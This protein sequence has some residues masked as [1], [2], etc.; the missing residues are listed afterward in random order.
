MARKRHLKNA[1]I[2]E[3]L[4]DL[5]VSGVQELSS[6]QRCSQQLTT[7]YDKRLK[8]HRQEFGF[9]M[10]AGNVV[11]HQAAPSVFGY[12]VDSDDGTQV[13][14]FRLD[15]FTFSRLSPYQTWESMRDEARRL[16]KLYES[17]AS[18]AMVTR[19]AVRYINVMQLPL[20]G[21]ELKEVL[22]MPPMLPEALP[23]SI[24]SFLTRI[25]FADPLVEA[26]V[27]LTQALE[28]PASG[29]KTSLT[30]DVDAFKDCER[31]PADDS[32]W[33][34]LESLRALKNEVFFESITEETARHFE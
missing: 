13:V 1:P 12:R 34:D 2:K 4:I 14:Q 10:N 16:W 22:T 25:V 28:S 3:A 23:H 9:S 5:R 27:I 18:P 7:P 6:L 15:G 8:L 19:I 24:A 31:G 33:A 26:S 11:S 20:A 21:R 29:Q 17:C 30:I 32:I